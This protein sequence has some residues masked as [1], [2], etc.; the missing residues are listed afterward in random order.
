MDMDDKGIKQNMG[1]AKKGVLNVVAD[2]MLLI[3]ILQNNLLEN[4]YKLKMVTNLVK[5]IPV[6]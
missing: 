2:Q 1:E 4:A 3:N 6:Y 5:F